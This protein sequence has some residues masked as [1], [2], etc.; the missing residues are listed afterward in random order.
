MIGRGEEWRR[1][2]LI[3]ATNFV[4]AR[5]YRRP[6]CRICVSMGGNKVFGNRKYCFAPFYFSVNSPS[7]TTEPTSKVL[8]P[9][10]PCQSTARGIYDDH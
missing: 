9:P 10:P 7:T 8:P 5:V 6:R 4:K 3:K 1:I 2:I